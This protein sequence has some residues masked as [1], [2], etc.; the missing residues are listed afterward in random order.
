MKKGSKVLRFG[1]Q[2]S[3]NIVSEEVAFDASEIEGLPKQIQ[4]VLALYEKL[5]QNIERLQACILDGR[6]IDATAIKIQCISILKTLDIGLDLH[7]DLADNLHTLYGHCLRRLTVHNGYTELEAI[8]S[9]RMVISRIRNVYL[10]IVKS[11]NINDILAK[12]TKTSDSDRKDD[13]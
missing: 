9:V 5:L 13:Q 12:G 4:A 1:R 8:D 2:A 11:E 10:K 3:L 6:S 7:G